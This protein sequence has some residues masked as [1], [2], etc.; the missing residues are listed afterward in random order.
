MCRVF[1]ETQILLSAET[2][3]Q[4][5]IRKLLSILPSPALH[6]RNNKVT[7]L[8]LLSNSLSSLVPS[9]HALLSVVLLTPS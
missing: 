7:S 8:T 9:P 2:N 1:L 4:H 3:T 6:A 5:I